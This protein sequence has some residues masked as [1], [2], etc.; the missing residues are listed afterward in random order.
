[1]MPA[2]PKKNAVVMGEKLRRYIEN[3]PFP[4]RESQ[5]LKKV[6]VSVGIATFPEDGAERPELVDRAD[7][8]MYRAKKLGRNAVWTAKTEAGSPK[9]Q[10]DI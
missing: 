8:A 7:G 4:G 6:T 1:M 3:F 5:P 9:R 2:T 10:V